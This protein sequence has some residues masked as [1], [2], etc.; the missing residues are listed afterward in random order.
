[1]KPAN[2]LTRYALLLA[3]IPPRFLLHNAKIFGIFCSCDPCQLK[4]PTD[5]SILTLCFSNCLFILD[6][7]IIPFNWLDRGP[8]V[9]CLALS[10]LQHLRSVL[11]LKCK[12]AADTIMAFKMRLHFLYWR[13]RS[14]LRERL[15]VMGHLLKHAGGMAAGKIS[16][17]LNGHH[18]IFCLIAAFGTTVTGSVKK[19]FNLCMD[20]CLD[21]SLNF[22]C[23]LLKRGL[24]VCLWSLACIGQKESSYYLA[25]SFS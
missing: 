3:A 4:V 23:M 16:V 6:P 5:D 18:A 12:L 13:L 1:M 22:S 14:C 15:S 24:M 11:C 9:L 25:P 20:S 2:S 8:V 7:E 17:I 19:I 10:W 21:I